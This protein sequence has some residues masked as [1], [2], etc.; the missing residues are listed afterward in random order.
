MTTNLTNVDKAG[1]KRLH[2][3]YVTTV[4]LV[5]LFRDHYN[6]IGKHIGWPHFLETFPSISLS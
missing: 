4:K 6:I 2:V 3:V 5:D 1:S